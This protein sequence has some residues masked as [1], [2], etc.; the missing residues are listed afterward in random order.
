[1]NCCWIKGKSGEVVVVLEEMILQPKGLVAMAMRCRLCRI[2][3]IY[4][5]SSG[6][7]FLGNLLSES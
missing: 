2:L 1:M 5:R 3:W 7:L 6:M 4:L